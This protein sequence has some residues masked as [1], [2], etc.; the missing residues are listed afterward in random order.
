MVEA[1]EP[2][3][4]HALEREARNRERMLREEQRRLS[5]SLSSSTDR[6]R[7]SFGAAEEAEKPF[8]PPTGP[9]AERAK[10]ARVEGGRTGKRKISVKYEDEVG[11]GDGRMG[12]GERER[13]MG[14]WG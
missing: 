6:K 4:P 13:E 11:D 8:A 14:R 10:R 7:K 5:S 2:S 3:D 9:S 12:R 1:K